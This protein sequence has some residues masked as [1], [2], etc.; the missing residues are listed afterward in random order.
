MACNTLTVNLANIE[1]DWDGI[2]LQ[3]GLAD[4]PSALALEFTGDDVEIKVSATGK[5][6]IV[7]TN[8]NTKGEL[9]G[10]FNNGTPV[11][12]KL[13]D[14][15]FNNFARRGDLEIRDLLNGETFTLACAGFMKRAPMTWGNNSDGTSECKWNFTSV[16]GY[17][18]AT[19]LQDPEA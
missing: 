7:Y 15:M 13:R 1:V 8:N 11:M 16:E 6:G 18:G 12:A 19:V 9:T 4:D 5:F 10:I 3:D 17:V 2:M 14:I